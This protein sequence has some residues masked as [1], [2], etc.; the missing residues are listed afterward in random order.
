MSTSD[1]HDIVLD[2]N[3]SVKDDRKECDSSGEHS[4]NEEEDESD[5]A[6]DSDNRSL[7][8]KKESKEENNVI[9]EASISSTKD[10]PLHLHYFC[11]KFMFHLHCSCI[12][13][14]LHS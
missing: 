13:F 2:N 14:G 1:L 4:E 6:S 10:K 3:N 8:N 11:I 12:A 7:N 5:N 9:K